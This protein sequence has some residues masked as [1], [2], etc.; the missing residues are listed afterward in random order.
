M[1]NR[2]LE[3]ESGNAS[4]YDVYN[5]DKSP[6]KQ[7]SDSTVKFPLV[8][9]ASWNFCASDS[10][11][12]CRTGLESRMLQTWEG[13]GGFEPEPLQTSISLRAPSES[14]SE[15]LRMLNEADQ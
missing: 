14:E 10:V 7:L 15:K 11:S 5:R 2:V 12:Y 1:P 6:G 9:K 4:R 3:L 8:G 13:T